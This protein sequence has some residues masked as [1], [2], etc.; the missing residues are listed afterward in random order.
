MKPA[1]T[2]EIV[3]N[4]GAEIYCER[5]GSGLGLYLSKKIIESPGGNIWYE[6]Q[7]D[8]YGKDGGVMYMANS[9][10]TETTFKFVIPASISKI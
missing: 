3:I 9:K 6:D 1:I 5:R 10:K 8:R 2:K 4:E 7:S